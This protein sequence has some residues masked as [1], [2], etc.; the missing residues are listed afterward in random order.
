MV[1]KIFIVSPGQVEMYESLKRALVGEDDVEIIYDR[2]L[3]QRKESRRR[4]VPLWS[5]GSLAAVGE[6]RSPSHVDDELRRRGWAVVRLD[7]VAAR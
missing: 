3:A 4:N 5:R 6:R 7:D 2:R 1:R